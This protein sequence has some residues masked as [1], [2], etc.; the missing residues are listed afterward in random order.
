MTEML[1]KGCH[2]AALVVSADRKRWQRHHR[3]K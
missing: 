3:F 1:N 2:S